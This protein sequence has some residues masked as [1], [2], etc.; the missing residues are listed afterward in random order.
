[1]AVDLRVADF[2]PDLF[3]PDL[4]VPGWEGSVLLLLLEIVALFLNSWISSEINKQ[5]KQFN[6]ADY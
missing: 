4:L 6:I 1:L 2:G 3:G 5:G